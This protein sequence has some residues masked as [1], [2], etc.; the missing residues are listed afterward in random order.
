MECVCMYVCVVEPFVC[1]D[2]GGWWLGN[3]WVYHGTYCY[4]TFS[5]HVCIPARGGLDHDFRF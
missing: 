2:G 1:F 5:E 4:Y 3:R